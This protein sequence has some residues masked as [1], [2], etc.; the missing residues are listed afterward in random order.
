MRDL[1]YFLPLLEV[2]LA[3]G[4]TASVNLTVYCFYAL[5]DVILNF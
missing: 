2:E 3:V 5:K 1:F 4:S